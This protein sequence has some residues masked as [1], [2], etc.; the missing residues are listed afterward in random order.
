MSK[1]ISRY[2]AQLEPV[3]NKLQGVCINLLSVKDH[4]NQLMTVFLND[5]ENS[6]GIFSTIFKEV[7]EIAQLSDIEIKMPRITGRQTQR[8]NILATSAEQ[9]FRLNIFI[10]YLDSLITSLKSRFSENSST[11]FSLSLLHPKNIKKQP[12]NT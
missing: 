9:Y 3:T 11:G 12:L 4:I 8:S 7:E 5:R 2:S 1:I 6:D 10:P